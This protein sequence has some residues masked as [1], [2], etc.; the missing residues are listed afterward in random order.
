M[1]VTQLSQKQKITLF[2]LVLCLGFIGL[3][4]FTAQSLSKMN[5]QYQQSGDVTAGSAALFATQAQLF[6]L[7]A[8][9]EHLSSNKVSEIKT[10]LAQLMQKVEGDKRLLAENN[11]ANEGNA[12]QQAVQAFND[13]MQPWLEIKGELGFN[14]DDGKLAELKKLAATI[15][16]KIDETG[17]VTINSDFQAMIKAQQNYLLQPNEQNLRLFNRA[18]AGFVS[19]SQSYAMLDLYKAEIEQFK[20]TFLRVSELSQQVKDIEKNLLSSEST[21][22]GVIESTAQR[23]E[24]V[25]SRYQ[26]L[27]EK[28]GEQ[29]LLSILVACVILAVLTVLLFMMVSFSLSKAL[30]QIGRVLEKLSSGDLSQRLAL[31]SNKKN[32]FNQLA[33]AV[34]KSCENLGGLVHVVQDRSVALSGDAVALNQAIDNLVRGQSDVMDQTQRLASA[35]EEVSLTTQQVSHS[36]EVVA[37]VSKASTLAAEEGSKVISAAIGSL[38]E[39]G[40]ILQSAA[41]HIQQLE[42]ASA[43]VDS[44]MD[45]INGIAEQTNLLALNAAIE[46]ARAGE[47]GRGFAVVADEVRSLAVRT[48]NAVSEISGTIETMKKESAEVILFMNQSE[49]TMEEGQS[50]G[51]QA[52]QALQRITQGTDEAAS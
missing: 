3:A 32:E 27:A 51:N 16:K 46:A 19:M 20:T 41:S 15:E 14:V 40:S 18:L 1:D 48:V 22:Q 23:L 38:R 24:E 5:S 29:T 36:L 30:T 39:V 50:K 4:V 17:M 9:R 28:A 34:N 35:T 10:R 52:M 11:F 6:E 49:Q 44:V 45:I 2:I 8:E 25:S 7:A 37:N 31:T 26:T 13:D 33:F 21:A 47:Q 42:Q 12:L 43:K